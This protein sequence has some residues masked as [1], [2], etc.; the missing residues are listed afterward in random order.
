[1]EISKCSLC[2]KKCYRQGCDKENETRGFTQHPVCRACYEK[3]YIRYLRSLKLK[4]P[5]LYLAERMIKRLESANSE[6]VRRRYY[7]GALI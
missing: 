5:D 3:H 2:G 4:F 6:L 1:M 7:L